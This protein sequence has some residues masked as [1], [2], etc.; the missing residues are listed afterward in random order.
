MSLF[1]LGVSHQTAPVAIREKVAVP[2]DALKEA[3]N[4]LQ[5]FTRVEE[6]SIV[7]TCNRTEIY[8]RQDSGDSKRITEWLCNYKSIHQDDLNPFIYTHPNQFAVNHAFRVA[9][10]LDSLVLG[11]PQILGQMKTAFSTA[12]QAGK[13]GKILNRLFQQSFSVAKKV[14][15][16]TAIGA[17]PVSVAY[18]A[19]NL[20]KQ[21]FADM[22]E[23]RVL[24]IGAGE[25]ITLAAQHLKA[26]GVQHFTI[27]NRTLERGIELANQ[28]GGHAIEL[29]E[30][31]NALADAEIIVSSTASTLPI[32]GKGMVE[33]TL[34]KRMNKR[35]F[36]VDLAVPRDIEP[37][38]A[39]LPNVYLYTVDDLREVVSENIDGRKQAAKQAE[40]IIEQ[41][42]S[43]FILW[44]NSLDHEPLMRALR[45]QTQEI[46]NNELERSMRRIQAGDSPEEV[47]QQFARSLS[48][49]FLHRP[50][51]ELN[52]AS[53][54]HV[55][56]AARTLFGLSDEI[57][58]LDSSHELDK[59]NKKH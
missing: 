15:S 34:K 59:A 35:M 39:K 27:A 9:S 57:Q 25:T 20:A 26:Q 50:T 11:E 19:V 8:C 21:I 43:E 36:M 37:E 58:T 6:A 22:S 7:S 48:Q 10:G 49:K 45:Q 32:I 12:H 40:K 30:I 14:R 4:D 18:A 54:E 24:M 52:E 1:S 42:S 5:R 55:L 41:H 47:L 28:L 56:A 44:L 2:D 16:D 51:I 13:T 33:S 29:S 3:L 31:P 17:N 23:Q 46:S 38:V 53:D